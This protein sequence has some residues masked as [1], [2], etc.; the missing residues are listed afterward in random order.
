VTLDAAII[1]GVGFDIVHNFAIVAAVSLGFYSVLAIA[2]VYHMSYGD[3]LTIGA[4]AA[5][6]VSTASWPWWAGLFCGALAAG[7]I[8]IILE[9]IIRRFYDRRDFSGLLFSWG[10]SLM[11][12]Q[13]IQ[14]AFGPSGRTVDGP[15]W[16]TWTVFGSTVPAFNMLVTMICLGIAATIWIM[17]KVGS[18]GLY[19]NGIA[20]SRYTAFSLGLPVAKITTIVFVGMSVLGG[21]IG[22]LLAPIRAVSPTMG[23]SYTLTA[24][25]TVLLFGSI[26]VRRVLWGAMVLTLVRSIATWSFG[27]SL[28]TAAMLL[29]VLVVLIVRK[30]FADP[31]SHASI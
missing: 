28:A 9:P 29:S 21:G 27:T 1:T 4:Y 23:V 5:S 26:S 30:Q 14:L 24:V 31:T 10:I 16:A 3:N 11:I 22:A 25:L 20:S 15:Q 18:F 19:L 6:I 2:G 8:S 13:G 12:V 17:W 7:V